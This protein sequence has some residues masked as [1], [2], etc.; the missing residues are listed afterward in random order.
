[1]ISFLLIISSFIPCHFPSQFSRFFNI[2]SYEVFMKDV[3]KLINQKRKR[4]LKNF[5]TEQ[6][7]VKETDIPQEPKVI[8]ESGLRASWQTWSE[9]KSYGVHSYV[10]WKEPRKSLHF[11]NHLFKSVCS[12]L[13][14][15]STLCWVPLV[16]RI[17]SSLRLQGACSLQENTFLTLNSRMNWL[18]GSILERHWIESSNK[19]F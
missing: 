5:R 4:N 8:C 13:T 3:R 6:R 10:W 12:S 16:W 11:I 9:K 7:Y 14:I 17:K 1:M 2:L 18:E 15:C 19:I